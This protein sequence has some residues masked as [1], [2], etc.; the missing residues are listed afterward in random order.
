[1]HPPKCNYA[2]QNKEKENTRFDKD[3]TGIRSQL[4]Y[5]Q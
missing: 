3:F 1:M 4:C 5:S 2:F